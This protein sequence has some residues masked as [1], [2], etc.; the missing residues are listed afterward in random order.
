MGLRITRLILGIVCILIT[1]VTAIVTLVEASKRADP[2]C[3]P[4]AD[5]VKCY[6]EALP[7]IWAIAIAVALTQLYI[8]W[9]KP[10]ERWLRIGLQAVVI[11]GALLWG[12]MMI[13]FI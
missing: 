5:H 3:G 8:W 7:G 2:Y 6:H 10:P 4:G 12:V 11:V 13:S 1:W 9:A